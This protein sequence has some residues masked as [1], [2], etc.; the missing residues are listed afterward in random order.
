[1]IAPPH[2]VAPAALA[3][4]THPALE[5]VGGPRMSWAELA[6][7]V[8]GRA[9]ALR[10]AGV[11]AGEVHA[12]LG[13]P[14]CAWIANFWALTWLGAAPAPLPPRAPAAELERA[15]AALSPAGLWVDPGH[16][17]AARGGWPVPAA[18]GAEPVD[19]PLQSPRLVVLS[20]GTTGPQ[21][22]IALTALQLAF[23]AFGSAIRLG[24]L[25][26]DRWLCPLPLH[27]IGG[28]SVL[29]RAAF[30]GTT[31]VLLPR[32]DAALAS[33]QL[34][35]VALA[36]LVPTMLSAILDA[37][38][39]E[40]FPRS[41][42]ALL[43]GGAETPPAL[44][45]RCRAIAAPVALSW[46]MSETASQVATRFPGDLSGGGH[47]GPP[48][49]FCR[50]SST[51]SG[52]LQV[53]GPTAP[54]GQI[55]TRDL[56]IVD[57]GRVVVQGRADDMI[58]SGGENIDPAEVEAALREHPAVIDAAVVGRSDARWGERP[59]AFVVLRA[60]V[61]SEALAAFCRARLAPFKVPDAFIPIA[62]LPEG[63]LG[64]RSRAALR[65]QAQ[66]RHR[67]EE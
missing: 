7:E 16:P 62:A 2:P 58:L 24:H 52:A 14:S 29:L 36:S 13:E 4:P 60:L 26:E 9:A 41:L 42:R 22:P 19:W 8:A 15:L 50:V 59:V 25:P 55:T 64:K 44:L 63:E 20:S 35:R 6:L 48:L 51:P 30:Y 33:A 31:A 34:D 37:R 49:P 12:L 43:I 38:K 5:V 65:Q 40:P 61:S 3:R 66:A 47:S 28:L 27:H 18:P 54:G 17:E 11:K 56:G 39:D 32:F 45:D 46:G 67:G 10:D 21:R 57:E 1:M 53:E 23:S